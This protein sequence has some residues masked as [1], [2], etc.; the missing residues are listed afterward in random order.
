MIKDRRNKNCGDCIT[1]AFSSLDRL[2]KILAKLGTNISGIDS[3]QEALTK[4]GF[5]DQEK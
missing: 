1:L 4:N 2:N 5:E 3:E